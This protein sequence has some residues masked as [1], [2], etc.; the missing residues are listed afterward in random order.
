[1]RSARY[2]LAVD[3]AEFARARRLR[4]GSSMEPEVAR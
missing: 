4:G 1:M 2:Y 3:M